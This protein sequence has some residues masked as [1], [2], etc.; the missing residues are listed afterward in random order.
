[1]DY[2]NGFDANAKAEKN[3]PGVEQAIAVLEEDMTRHYRYVGAPVQEGMD[4][5]L[6]L[7][8]QE[9]TRINYLMAEMG[10]A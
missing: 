7:L 1:M 8:R 2:Y 9:L 4:K 3:K 6:E 5:A 10:D